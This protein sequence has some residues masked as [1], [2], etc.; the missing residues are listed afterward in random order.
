MQWIFLSPHLDDVALSCGGL[1]WEL[2]RAGEAVAI[3]SICAG[4]PPPGPFSPL[5]DE[6]HA[7][8]QTGRDAV[9]FRREEDARSAAALG[10]GLRHFA[11]PDVIYRRYPDTGEP[12]ITL[13]EELFTA[14]PEDYLV[15]ELANLLSAETPPA[16]QVVCPLALGRHVDHLLVRGAAERAGLALLYYADYPYILSSPETQAAM[17][18]GAWLRQPAAISEDGLEAWVTAII[19]HHSQI[20]TFWRDDRE[21]ALS[22]SNY[23]GG[24]G[25]RLWRLPGD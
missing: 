12:V 16:S 4:D 6:L 19:A 10:A 11:Y 2:V 15:S 8:W 13:N 9:A 24:G 20:S 3:W 17:E 18:G 14:T 21:M 22:L 7:R 23:C 25:G 1:V 5:A